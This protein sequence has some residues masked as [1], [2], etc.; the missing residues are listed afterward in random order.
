MENLV[1]VNVEY[2]VKILSWQ[3]RLWILS[4][5]C[6]VYHRMCVEVVMF[7]VPSKNKR[8]LNT[9]LLWETLVVAYGPSVAENLVRRHAWN[10]QYQYPY[11]RSFLATHQHLL[12]AFG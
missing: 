8:L 9:A 5:I 11:V 12:L 10:V 4:L 3:V 6:H 7:R 2:R 1:G